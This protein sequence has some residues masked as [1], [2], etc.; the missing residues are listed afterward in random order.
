MHGEF[1]SMMGRKRHCTTEGRTQHSP[2][3]GGQT[4]LLLRIKSTENET[5]AVNISLEWAGTWMRTALSV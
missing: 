1:P 5:D 2:I 3:T 4:W